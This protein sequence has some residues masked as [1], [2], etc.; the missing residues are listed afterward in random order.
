M[1]NA[2]EK[3]LRRACELGW[4]PR[5]G[6]GGS[7]HK[8]RRVNLRCDH[9]LSS[10]EIG[11]IVRIVKPLWVQPYRNEVCLSLI[12]YLIKSSV[13]EED[14]YKVIDQLTKLTG[15]EER[16][17]RLSQVRYHYHS[18]TTVDL[19]GWAGLRSVARTLRKEGVLPD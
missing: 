6:H 10:E 5:G 17:S 11:E 4:K 15:D 8:H 16:S 18:R 13:Q 1:L 2:K 14:T 3:I 12:G 7:T 19:K 9:P